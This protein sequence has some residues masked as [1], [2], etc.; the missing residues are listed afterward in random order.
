MDAFKDRE[1][2]YENKFVHD[3][4][5]RFKANARRL[6]LVGLWAA[7]LLG[8]TGD[9]AS[10]YALEVVKSDFEEAG[11]EDVIRKL[12]ADLEGRADERTIRARMDEFLQSAMKQ[13]MS[14]GA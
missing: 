9:E 14:E 13:I 10:A 4:E 6:R 5:L 1:K 11:H 3:E 12:K 8:K 7:D 2:G